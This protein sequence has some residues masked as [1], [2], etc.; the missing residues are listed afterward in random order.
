MNGNG[1]LDRLERFGKIVQAL[2]VPLM[3][4]VFVAWY[5][6]WIPSPLSAATQDVRDRVVAHDTRVTNLVALRAQ[7][8]SQLA[9][10]LNTLAKQLEQQNKILRFVGCAAIKETD[11]RRR[12]LED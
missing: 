11:L 12:C 10:T 5:S 3:L 1:T 2:G 8:D 9:T 7:T 6:G 4:G